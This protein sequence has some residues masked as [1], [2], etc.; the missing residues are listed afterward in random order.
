MQEIDLI[1]SSWYWFGTFLGEWS[2][3]EKL[4]EIK[5]PLIETKKSLK[6]MMKTLYLRAHLANII[7]TLSYSKM[8]A[9]ISKLWL[10]KELSIRTFFSYPENFF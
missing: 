9:I 10:L 7:T 1:R 3:S 5:P 8:L 2:Q 4:P 6:A